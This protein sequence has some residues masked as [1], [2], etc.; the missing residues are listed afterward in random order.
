MLNVQARLAEWRS[1]YGALN[2]AEQRLRRAR[3]GQ[4]ECGLPASA[5][6]T[7][8]RRL[9]RESERALHDVDVALAACRAVPH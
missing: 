1:L 6:E 5:L 2:A 9:Q 7:E 8:V 4:C 3:D